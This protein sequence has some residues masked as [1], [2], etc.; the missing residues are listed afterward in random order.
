M[1]Q[2][3]PGDRAGKEAQKCRVLVG[4]SMAET[5]HEVLGGGGAQQGVRKGAGSGGY[6]VPVHVTFSP[7]AVG[8][9]HSRRL[10]VWRGKKGLLL[11]EDGAWAKEE[12]RK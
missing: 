12:P 11:G 1:H 3:R 7:W 6:Q 5:R 10:W 4:L 9:P 8:M 2:S